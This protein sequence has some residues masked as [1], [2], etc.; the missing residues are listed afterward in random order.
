VSGSTW[1]SALDPAGPQAGAASWISW[2]L[3]IGCTVIYLLVLAS[4]ALAV[5]RSHHPH[6][7]SEGYRRIRIGVIGAVALTVAVLLG[8]MITSFR[9]TEVVAAAA[10]SKNELRIEVYGRQWWWE[11]RYP[12]ER[13]VET[14][15]T[16]NE[17]HVPVG[18]PVSVFLTSLDVVHSFWVPRLHGKIDLIPSRYNTIRFE[19]STPGLYR[20]QCSEFCGL[21]HAHML[22]HVVAHEREEF[23]AWLHGQRLPAREPATPDQARGREIFLDS[24]CIICHSIR[25]TE[26]WGTVGPDLTHFASRRFLGAGTRPNTREH[27]VQWIADSQRLKP[28]NRMP[29]IALAT[30]DL[31]P[32]ARYLESLE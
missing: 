24:P 14:V 23:A 10:S 12:G 15:V 21:S 7:D 29:R 19:V 5:R 22:F 9:E 6:T 25:G 20:G 17:I 26:A 31:E 4:V 13:P 18:V 8:F 27:L 32:L 2:V 28:G 30:A 11:V 16:A 1:P 3:I